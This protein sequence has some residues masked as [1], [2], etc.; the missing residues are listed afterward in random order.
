MAGQEKGNG[1]GPTEAQV[2]GELGKVMD[3]DLKKDIVSLGFVRNLSIDNGRGRVR[4]NLTTRPVRLRTNCG[5]KLPV[6]SRR[7]PASGT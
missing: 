1:S 5:T 7:Y 3:P 2:L 4:H 6:W